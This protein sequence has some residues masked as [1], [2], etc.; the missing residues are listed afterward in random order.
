M[1][2]LGSE[3]VHER[4]R[5][6][7]PSPVGEAPPAASP[8]VFMQ[9]PPK[10]SKAPALL[11]VL[12]VLAVVGGIVES[13]KRDAERAAERR[14]TAEELSRAMQTA[15]ALSADT[16][17]SASGI[18]PLVATASNPDVR[19]LQE[20]VEE[21]R[22]L[23]ADY[24]RSML[25]VNGDDFMGPEAIASAAG[26]R[27]IRA[28]L[29]QAT[30]DTQGF[31]DHMKSAKQRLF[32][33]LAATPSAVS[34]HAAMVSL[35]DRALAANLEVIDRLSA[36][37]D[38]ADRHPPVLRAHRLLFRT[39]EDLAEWRR[40]GAAIKTSRVTLD[41]IGEEAQRMERDGLAQMDRLLEQMK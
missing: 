41:R 39:E 28:K 11:A 13:E 9:P 38:F 4:G 12:V 20:H 22:R 8:F 30:V 5:T 25:A 3:A 7:V 10:R 16:G 23:N 17:A 32:A 35:L 40:L 6:G 34:Q 19:L 24:E 36:L 27:A 1:N 29:Q 31:F 37:N 18:A 26:R 15:R 33:R 21:V 14:A 2:E